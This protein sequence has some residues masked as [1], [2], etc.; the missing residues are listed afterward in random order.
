MQKEIYLNYPEA[1]STEIKVNFKVTQEKNIHNIECAVDTNFK[2]PNWLQSTRFNM[3]SLKQNNHF[4][5]LFEDMKY[6]KNLDTIHFIDYCYAKIM[7]S[8]NLSYDY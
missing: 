4:S 2:L 8:L 7:E 6:N 3:T 5:L 1:S